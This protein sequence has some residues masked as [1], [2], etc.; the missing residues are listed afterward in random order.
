MNYKFGKLKKNKNK[1]WKTFI[2]IIMHMNITVFVQQ[3]TSK[4][5]MY[6]YSTYESFFIMYHCVSIQCI[7]GLSSSLQREEPC[8]ES[9]SG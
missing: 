6:I 3:G 5:T 2:Y 8:L 4:E 9:A 7:S 1:K